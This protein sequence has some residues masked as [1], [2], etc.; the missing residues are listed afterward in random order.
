MLDDDGKRC[1]DCQIPHA[2]LQSLKD[3]SFV[4]LFEP[5]DDQALI[6]LTGFDHATFQELH[7]LFGPFF[8]AFTPFSWGADASYLEVNPGKKLVTILDMLIALQGWQLFC[9]GLYS[10]CCLGTINDVWGYWLYLE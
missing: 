5:G 9:H 4:T 2:A 1:H 7:K 8:N 10:R 6:A 3:S